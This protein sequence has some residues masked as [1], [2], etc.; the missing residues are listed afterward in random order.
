MVLPRTDAGRARLGITVT[1]K[2]SSTAVGRNR[3][4]RVVREVFRKNRE[5]FP[6]GCDVVVIA[7][8]ES[9]ALGYG[10]VLAEVRDAS[11]SMHRKAGA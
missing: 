1:K 5:L 2:V 3:V 11:P 10:D 7:K 9:P 8:R 6:P 4:K